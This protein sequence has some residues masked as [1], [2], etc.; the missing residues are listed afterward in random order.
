MAALPR[1]DVGF[2]TAE[3][4]TRRDVRAF[5]L[6][7][8][9]FD[10]DRASRAQRQLEAGVRAAE[11]RSEPP[12]WLAQGSPDEDGLEPLATEER[13]AVSRLLEP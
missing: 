8:F 13:A 4:N 1:V 3:S 9:A 10:P 12:S 5:V 7:S 2:A 11:R 6:L